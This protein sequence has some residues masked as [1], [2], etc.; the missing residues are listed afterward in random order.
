MEVKRYAVLLLLITQTVAVIGV[1]YWFVAVRSCSYAEDCRAEEETLP[2]SCMEGVPANQSQ[3]PFQWSHEKGYLATLQY[4]GQQGASVLSVLNQQCFAGA[5][6]NILEPVMAV[7]TFTATA[8]TDNNTVPFSDL[9]DLS[10]FNNVSANLGYSKLLLRET[11]FQKAPKKIIFVELVESVTS[12]LEVINIVWKS[13]SNSSCCNTEGTITK[14]RILSRLLEKGFCIVGIVTIQFRGINCVFTERELRNVIFGKWAISEVTV[15]FSH[16]R[17]PWTVP[18]ESLP[19]CA[20]D[21]L[22]NIRQYVE[23]SR[24]IIEDAKAYKQMWGSGSTRTVAVMFRFERLALR[25]CRKDTRAKSIACINF[26]VNQAL[27]RTKELQAD[28]SGSNAFVTMDIGSYGTDTMNNY[29]NDTSDFNF[30]S[31]GESIIQTLLSSTLTFE[32]WEEKFT[33][34]SVHKGYIAA[35]QRYIASEADCLV[36]VGGGFFQEMALNDYIS[37]HSN[38]MFRCTRFVCTMNT[39][40]LKETVNI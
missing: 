10:H 2:S 16:W 33:A 12:N 24:K 31:I 23:P 36:L 5:S 40:V 37:K 38:K 11:F 39:D 28:K 26:C 34:I 14:S 3:F 27:E 20:L 25:T 17:Y 8:Q 32:E 19:S 22:S 1:L 30:T 6:F 35:V 21:K 29:L 4:G 13:H 7:S 15:V 9:I 18:S